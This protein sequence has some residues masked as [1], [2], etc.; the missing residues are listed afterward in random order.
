[1]LDDR[2]DGLV[3]IGPTRDGQTHVVDRPQDVVPRLEGGVAL[4]EVLS[5]SID[6]AEGVP[7]T[8]P[9]HDADNGEHRQNVE[10]ERQERIGGG[11]AENLDGTDE[12]DGG[13]NH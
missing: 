7:G 9:D 8:S 4:L 12:D 13:D 10:G 11:V 1:M 2:G 6:P 5:Q 3:R